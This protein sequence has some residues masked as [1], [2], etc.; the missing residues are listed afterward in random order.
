[1]SNGQGTL[2]LVYPLRN[3]AI[4]L[5]CD[6]R[7]HE[8]IL[9]DEVGLIDSQGVRSPNRAHPVPRKSAYLTLLLRTLSSKE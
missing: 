7:T 4:S 2:D 8:V 6:T 1:M 3:S 5:I 9:D